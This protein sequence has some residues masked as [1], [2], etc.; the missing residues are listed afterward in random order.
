[1]RGYPVD[2]EMGGKRFVATMT[3]LG[4]LHCWLIAHGGTTCGPRGRYGSKF[5]GTS[6]LKAAG[7]VEWRR[8]VFSWSLR[9]VSVCFEP[10][11]VFLP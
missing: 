2:V 9:M 3:K 6:R 5:T 8:Q 1:M 11:L 7:E 10:G 4:T